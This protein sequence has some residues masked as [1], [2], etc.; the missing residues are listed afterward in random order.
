MAALP[1]PNELKA[2]T[3]LRFFA[4][5]WVLLYHFKDHLGFNLGQIGLIAD[6]WLGVDL[7]FMLS[8][9]ILAHV[10]LGQAERG[11]FR[12]AH[13]LQNRLARI[14]PMHLAALAAMLALYALAHATGAGIGDP[15]AFRLADLPAHLLLIHAWGATAQV[16]WNFPSWSISA[17]WGAY[18]L[19]PLAAGLALRARTRPGL[20]LGAALAL[21]L[22]AYAVLDG[23][24]AQLPF[25]GRGFAEMTAQIGLLRIVPTFFAGV[26]LYAFGKART[27]PARAAW[28]LALIAAG[29][30]AIVSSFA[31]WEGLAWPALA[32]LI[33]ALAETA[34]RG[35][36]GFMG[37]RALVLLG[38]ASYALYMIHLPIDIVYFHALEIVGIDANAGFPVRLAALAG[39]FIVAIAASLFAYAWFEE[40]A[41]RWVRALPGLPRPRLAASR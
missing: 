29:W 2:L 31:L 23:L 16:G 5:F 19:F 26:C 14:Y 32:A 20:M 15:N 8:G 35:R 25:L 40:P 34:R 11:R 21:C 3:S 10:Y 18:L 27:L 1:Y 38:A 33:L 39:V 9:F 24:H 4:A 13:F 41:R 37:A 30:I 6:G 36:E 17:E 7:F 12:Y 28:P 22:A